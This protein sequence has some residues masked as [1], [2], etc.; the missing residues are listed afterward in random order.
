[1]AFDTGLSGLDTLSVAGGVGGGGA[2]L[3]RVCF[4]RLPPPPSPDVSRRRER[5]SER[6]VKCLRSEDAGDVRVLY[7][8]FRADDKGVV[9]AGVKNPNVR[10]ASLRPSIQIYSP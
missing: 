6:E 2:L 10:R 5:V 1:M 4:G 7:G 8:E 3:G 9:H